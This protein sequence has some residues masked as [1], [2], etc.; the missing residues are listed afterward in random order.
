MFVTAL[1]LCCNTPLW[2]GEIHDAAARG[3]LERVKALVKDDPKIVN[4]TDAQGRTPLHL[5]VI[6]GQKAVVEFLLANK[7]DTRLKGKDGHTASYWATAK[8]YAEITELLK[9]QSGALRVSEAAAAKPARASPVLAEYITDAEYAATVSELLRRGKFEELDR[10]ANEIRQKNLRFK[11]GAPKLGRFYGAMAHW[12]DSGEDSHWNGWQTHLERWVQQQPDS[13]SARIV[14]GWFWVDNAARART[15]QVAA[16]VTEER[17]KT[18]RERLAKAMLI[19]EEADKL[20]TKDPALYTVMLRASLGQPWSK[21][22]YE[23]T[24]RKATSLDPLYFPAYYAKAVHLLP[25]WGGGD[26]QLGAFATEAADQTRTELGEMLYA[27]VVTSVASYNDSDD[28]KKD[29]LFFRRNQFSWKHTKQGFLD[30]EK[31]YPDSIINRNAFCYFACLAGDRETARGLFQQIKDQWDVTLWKTEARFESSRHWADATTP[32]PQRVIH[33]EANTINRLA[34]SPNGKELA[35][36]GSEGYLTLWDTT[37]SR[38]LARLEGTQ[39]LIRA[40][41]FSPDGAFLAGGGADDCTGT[42]LG[43]LLLWHVASGRPRASLHGHRAPIWSLAFMPDGKSLIS[44]GG[45]V[46]HPGE[47]LRWDLS[48]LKPTLLQTGHPNSVSA[49]AVSP[50]GKLIGFG[51]WNGV[52]VWDISS[53]TFANNLLTKPVHSDWVVDLAF[54]PDGKRLVSASGNYDDSS[55]PGQAKLWRAADGELLQRHEGSTY[56]AAFAPNGQLFAT[57]SHGKIEIWD[58]VSGELRAMFCGPWG[59]FL[60]LGISPDGKQLVGGDD[61]GAV[62]FWNLETIKLGPK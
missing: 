57:G 14:L 23:K 31:A 40:L 11:S 12:N 62:R 17:W 29:E 61:S 38:Q 55:Q 8:G 60:A 1:V 24:F 2:A 41:A 44:S 56:S 15:A 54:S 25:R 9:N 7:A 49:V 39:G 10:L 53:N 20:P 13:V 6:N 32:D 35:V 5:A 48:T 46:N 47:V 4:A 30:L 19:L 36:A 21:E 22:T 52:S 50:E 43:N 59:K 18:Y 3:N 58:A 16:R 42:D 28:L 33:T 26:G 45:F 34:F 27:I 51:T 37:T